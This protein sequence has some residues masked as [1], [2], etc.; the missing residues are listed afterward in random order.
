MERPWSHHD[1]SAV[2]LHQMRLFVQSEAESRKFGEVSRVLHFAV[3]DMHVISKDLLPSCVLKSAILGQTWG[4][5]HLKSAIPGQGLAKFWALKSAIFG[6]EMAWASGGLVGYWSAPFMPWHNFEYNLPFVHP[7]HWI[8]SN[9]L[10]TPKY[11]QTPLAG[12]CRAR[13]HQKIHTIGCGRCFFTTTMPFLRETAMHSMRCQ[14]TGAWLL[15]FST[16]AAILQTWHEIH[17]F[18]QAVQRRGLGCRTG[19]SE[20]HRQSQSQSP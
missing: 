8:T 13:N 3:N 19:S 10:W 5:I 16:R 6:Q 4:P 12:P 15:Y 7:E 18:D 20:I 9:T 2:E 11:G 14:A 17:V 1:V